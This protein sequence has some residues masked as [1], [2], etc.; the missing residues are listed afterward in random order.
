MTV[1]VLPGTV[2]THS[3]ARVGVTGS[4]LD[5]SE[6]D[7]RVEHCRDKMAEYMRVRP[8]D[9]N[10]CSFGELAQAAGT[11]RLLSRIGPRVREPAAWSMARPTAGGSGT[12][13]TLVPLPHTRRTRWPCSSP[14]SAMSLPVAS[15]IRSPSRPSMAT[16]AKSYGLGEWRAAVS[17]ASNWRWVNP[18]V[19]DSAGPARARRTR[20]GSSA[21]RIRCARGSSP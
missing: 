18:R 2:V 1:E 3:G 11:P 6:I 16:R 10:A 15:K 14:R 12:R 17:R 5:I 19:G 8:G 20:L 7:A 9:L 21:D 4:D 13:I